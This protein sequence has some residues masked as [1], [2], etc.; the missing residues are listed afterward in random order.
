MK[1]K[2]ALDCR[3]FECPQPVIQTKD[4]LDHMDEGILCVLVDN[5][6][7][8]SN[9]C[10]YAESQ[11]HKVENEEKDDAFLIRIRK[12]KSGPV[13]E[14]PP[15]ECDIALPRH[16][17]IYITSDVLGKGDD[18][19]GRKLMT[20]YFESLLHFAKQI[21]HVI[22]MNSGVKLAIDGSPVLG[23]MMAL[24]DTGVEILACGTCLD[25]FDIKERQQVG[26]VTNMY[27]AF[28]IMSKAGKVLTP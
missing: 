2:N 24:E 23:Q 11:G 20:A 9:V 18:D 27:T 17:V 19:L 15:I 4:R 3:G 25:F 21:S 26:I 12:G 1:N 7:A 28:E 16:I 10:R 5:E 13:S 14:P 6:A 22:L 8:L